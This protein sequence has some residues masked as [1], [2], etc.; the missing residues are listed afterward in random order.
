MCIRD[1]ESR[2]V[3]FLGGLSE[4]C[5]GL[6]KL[7]RIGLHEL[8]EFGDSRRRE[9]LR[10]ALLI[11]SP[12][13]DEGVVLSL[14]EYEEAAA[15]MLGGFPAAVAIVLSVTGKFVLAQVAVSCVADEN[16]A[17]VVDFGGKRNDCLLYTSRCV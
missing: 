16:E 5:D 17:A 10:E 13:R 1:R 12:A 7:L 2:V 8:G 4:I 11:Q 9:L 6:G 3:A 14:V 15:G